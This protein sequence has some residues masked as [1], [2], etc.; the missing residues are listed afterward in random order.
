MLITNN[1][2]RKRRGKWNSIAYDAA[3]G[4]HEFRL[5][6]TLRVQTRTDETPARAEAGRIEKERA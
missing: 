5:E 1:Y 3:R 4:G 2:G 6:T